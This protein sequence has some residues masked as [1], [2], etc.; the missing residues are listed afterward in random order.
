MEQNEFKSGFVAVVGKPNVGKSTLINYLLGQKIAA[1]SPRPQTTRRNQLGIVTTDSS[2]IIFIDTPGIH[3]PVSKLS[4]AMN[5]NAVSTLSDADCVLWLCD[6]S[7]KPTQEDENVAQRI[8]NV[9]LK[10]NVIL[11]L[12]KTDLVR[13]AVLEQN[14]KAYQDLCPQAKPIVISSRSGRNCKELLQMIEA[15]LPVGPSYYDKDQIT[16]LYEREIAADLIRESLLNNLEDEVPHSIAVRIDEY[17]DRTETNSYILAEIILDRESHKGIVL[18]KNG[19][20][21][22]KIGSDARAEI[23][24]MTGRKIYLELKVKVVK[25]WQNNPN[26]LK[27]LGYIRSDK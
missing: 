25:D 9:H 7:E 24:K 27:T 15:M 11:G 21:I 4:E 17:V 22:K 2:Q 14:Q 19:L 26:L 3:K 20:M 1:V 10:D 12:N 5:E 18:G 13:E 16:D 6:V 23:E 8:S